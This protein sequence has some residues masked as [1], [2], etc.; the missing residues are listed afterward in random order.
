M[1]FPHLGTGNILKDLV[2]WL[3][4]SL[5]NFKIS[6]LLLNWILRTKCYSVM[7]ISEQLC[8]SLQL[9]HKWACPFSFICPQRAWHRGWTQGLSWQ[10]MQGEQLL[11]N[12]SVMLFVSKSNELN[13]VYKY[14]TFPGITLL[15]YWKI[16]LFSIHNSSTVNVL[17]YSEKVWS[18]LN[19]C[20]LKIQI[21]TPKLYTTNKTPP[22]RLGWYDDD[23][24]II[25]YNTLCILWFLFICF[26]ICHCR[27]ALS[28]VSVG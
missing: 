11:K 25:N 21:Q 14:C 12:V 17:Y 28:V 7:T 4:R 9:A 13:L 18:V 10:G 23:N 15:N 8:D 24:I 3:H 5:L 2:G 26:K 16:R 27:K 20:L 6:I 19:D 22:T 1:F